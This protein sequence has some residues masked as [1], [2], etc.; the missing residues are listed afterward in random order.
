MIL[1]PQLSTPDSSGIS[2]AWEAI[3]RTQRAH[4]PNYLLIHQPD[5]A[6][7]AGELAEQFSIPGKP[8]ITEAIVTGISLHDE[9]WLMFDSG[10]EKLQATPAQ[11]TLA[12]TPVNGDGRPLSFSDIKAGDFLRAWCASIEA[13]EAV[14]PIA[15]LIVSGHFYR[16]G[17]F[18]ASI[19][20]YSGD[21]GLVQQF[22]AGEERRR[23][24]LSKLESRS[25]EEI[26]YWTDVLQ[27]CDLLSL[28]LCCGS[29]ESVEFPQRIG[30][31]NEAIVLRA[32]DGLNVLSPSPLEREAKFR[33]TAHSFPQGSDAK[34]SWK[35]R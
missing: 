6:R 18:G 22:I 32:K 3:A 13:A 14:A 35:V 26:E 31:P 28:Y 5:H 12:G 1:R 17:K 7:L 34:L 8:A 29:Q 23:E 30:E 16:L 4:S 20:H 25:P 19:G 11:Y 33:L 21:D 9:G 24:R 2:S 15:G 27:F 10:A